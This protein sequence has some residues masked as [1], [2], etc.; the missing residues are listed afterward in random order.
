M[1]DVSPDTVS[2]EAQDGSKAG[3]QVAQA[4]PSSGTSKYSVDL[5]AEEQLWGGHAISDHVAKSAV[6]LISEVENNTR[7]MQVNG[8]PVTNYTVYSSYDSV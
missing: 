2:P 1:S 8:I 6:E 3:E 7:R 4:P 5:R